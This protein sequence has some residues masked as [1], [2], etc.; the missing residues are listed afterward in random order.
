MFSSSNPAACWA[1]PTS[2][3]SA[4]AV[5]R[6]MPH[7]RQLSGM[8]KACT[9]VPPGPLMAHCSWSLSTLSGRLCPVKPT[10][11][12]FAPSQYSMPLASGPK[13]SSSRKRKLSSAPS[14]TAGI[15]KIVGVQNELA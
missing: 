11:L 15:E 7:S 14:A 3:A 12:T 4:N 8:K 9:H 1:P 2:L 6:T 5:P 10:P 13:S